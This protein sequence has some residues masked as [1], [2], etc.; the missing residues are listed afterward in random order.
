MLSGGGCGVG[1]G[2]SCRRFR[3]CGGEAAHDGV[4]G[5][6]GGVVLSV[7]VRGERCSLVWAELGPVGGHDLF[8]FFPPAVLPGG[9]GFELVTGPLVVLVG[10]VLGGG[11]VEVGLS[12]D[13]HGAVLVEDDGAAGA[14]DAVRHTG[15]EALGDVFGF[16]FG[17]GGVVLGAA[18]AF[19]GF[20][21]EDASEPFFGEGGSEGVGAGGVEDAFCSASA[22]EAG[23]FGEFVCPSSGFLAGALFGDDGDAEGDVAV[24][25]LAGVL[26]HGKSPVS[27]LRSSSSTFESECAEVV[28]VDGFAYPLTGFEERRPGLLEVEVV[29]LL[30]ARLGVLPGCGHVLCLSSTGWSGD[31]QCAQDGPRSAAQPRGLWIARGAP[32]E[33][34]LAWQVRAA[35][36]S[37]LVLPGGPGRGRRT[38]GRRR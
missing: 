37:E 14:V 19:A 33:T 11:G 32:V 29:V 4:C 2:A 13:R 24:D 22:D 23:L 12:R 7:P 10:A 5:G 28:V 31:C 25:G 38:R 17:D 36:T 18:E 21:F 26:G 34:A 6:S 15:A 3:G 27:G 35:L 1:D 16:G 9:K 30:G 8:L 20:V